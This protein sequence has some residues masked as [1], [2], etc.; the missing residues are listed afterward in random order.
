MCGGVRFD[1]CI[2]SGRPGARS[3]FAPQVQRSGRLL[4]LLMTVRM[5]IFR[6]PSRSL[7]SSQWDCLGC[8]QRGSCV[9]FPAPGCSGDRLPP[10]GVSGSTVGSSCALCGSA[11]A[12]GAADR[13]QVEESPAAEQQ[14][15]TC[16]NVHPKALK[17]AGRPSWYRAQSH[18][19]ISAAA[20]LEAE[21][22]AEMWRLSSSCQT[23]RAAGKTSYPIRN[24]EKKLKSTQIKPIL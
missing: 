4:Q 6:V 18:F 3:L 19:R 21:Q 5:R 23:L 8:N 9:G 17:R 24:R 14:R 12:E 13:M 20:G 7:F 22:S 10:C 15:E 16:H 2:R 1:A 11:P